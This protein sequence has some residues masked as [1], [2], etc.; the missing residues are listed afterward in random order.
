[1][2]TETFLY[3]HLLHAVSG[4]AFK[5]Y[6]EIRCSE[7]LFDYI[8]SQEKCVFT[9]QAQSGEFLKIVIKAESI[10]AVHNPYGTVD[11]IN[12]EKVNKKREN[13]IQ[14]VKNKQKNND[15]IR[16]GKRAKPTK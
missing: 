10:I 14:Q 16:I 2:T 1:M 6:S 5:V 4:R 7:D 15:K 13:E 11:R 9:E 12:P 3:A 8:Q